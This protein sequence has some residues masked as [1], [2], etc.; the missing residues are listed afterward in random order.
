MQKMFTTGQHNWPV[1]GNL[2]PAAMQVGGATKKGPAAKLM[3]GLT[4]IIN[5][6]PF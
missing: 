4:Q 6:F 1:T 3:K 5:P 2:A